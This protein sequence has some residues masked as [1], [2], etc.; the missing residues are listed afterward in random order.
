MRGCLFYTSLVCLSLLSG[1]S[2]L[3]GRENAVDS[4]HSMQ[5]EVIKDPVPKGVSQTDAF[6][7]LKK[8]VKVFREAERQGVPRYAPKDY[9]FASMAVRKAINFVESNPELACDFSKMS[10]VSSKH[11]IYKAIAAQDVEEN[12]YTYH[13]QLETASRVAPSKESLYRGVSDHKK[14]AAQNITRPKVI[15]KTSHIEDVIDPLTAF[16]PRLDSPMK[17]RRAEIQKRSNSE[18]LYR[19][20]HTAPKLQDHLAAKERVVVSNNTFYSAFSD[21]GNSSLKKGKDAR[22][23]FLSY[24]VVRGD[25]LWLISKK[26]FHDAQLWPSIFRSNKKIIRNPDLIYPG[27]T[28]TFRPRSELTKNEE[29][30]LRGEAVSWDNARKVARIKP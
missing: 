14:V 25:A 19:G 3:F 16:A 24:D 28:F 21:K 10:V 9:E 17:A 5:Q 6:N 29:F 8:A 30:L 18:R 20:M 26:L 12:S 4:T 1:C 2:T 7:C 13:K 23:Y 27:Q 11:G 15:Q 22:G